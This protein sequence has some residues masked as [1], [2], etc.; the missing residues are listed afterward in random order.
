MYQK[1]CHND[2]FASHPD[3][4]RAS[5]FF[6]LPSGE[7]VR[8]YESDRR[9]ANLRMMGGSVAIDVACANETTHHHD[10]IWEEKGENA[11]RQILVEV[12]SA[13]DLIIIKLLAWDLP[14]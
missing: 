14:P 1:M 6:C 11:S 7:Y 13:E 8:T 10:C 9:G 5:N 12:S 3:G 2:V 4:R